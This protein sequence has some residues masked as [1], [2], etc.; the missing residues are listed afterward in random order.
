MKV[1]DPALAYSD[2]TQKTKLTYQDYVNMPD[3]G[4]RYELI[5]GELIMVAAP[6]TIHQKVIMN[7]ISKI[8]P[9]VE[10]KK[11]GELFTSPIDVVLSEHTTLQPDIIFIAKEHSSIITEKNI[12]GAPD[13]VIEIL[14]PSSFYYDWFDKKELYEQ[15]GVKE[16]WIVDP[17]RRWADVYILEGKKYKRIQHEEQTGILT[18]AV[19]NGFKIDL[20]EMFAAEA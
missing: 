17:L 5:D 16:Y 7:I 4:H 10:K 9:F 20:Q 11:Y 2:A 19:L 14:S 18:S 3:D 12:Q 13:L 15:H 8:L 1:K 6:L